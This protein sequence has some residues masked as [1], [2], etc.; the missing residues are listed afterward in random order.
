MTTVAFRFTLNVIVCPTMQY[1]KSW[2]LPA[3]GCPALTVQ[4]PPSE[5]LNCDGSN[6]ASVH[7][8]NDV[9]LPC[10]AIPQVRS[11]LWVPSV[12][13]WSPTWSAALARS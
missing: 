12:A 5:S 13:F 1:E 3:V 9:S 6:G 11:S 2:T 4:V 10:S 7:S 8:P